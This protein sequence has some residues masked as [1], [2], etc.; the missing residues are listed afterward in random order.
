MQ[1]SLVELNYPMPISTNNGRSQC[2][3]IFGAETTKTVRSFQ[4]NQGLSADGIAGRDT[5]HR[6]DGL[7]R[8]G[9]SS[10]ASMQRLQWTMGSAWT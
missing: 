5:L 7:V 10:G 6:L 2:D 9:E 3:G 1:E 4:A 8:S